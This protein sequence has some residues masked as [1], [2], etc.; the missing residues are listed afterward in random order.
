MQVFNMNSISSMRPLNKIT[1]VYYCAVIHIE[2]VCNCSLRGEPISVEQS[3]ACLQ[4]GFHSR[5]EAATEGSN[6]SEGGGVEGMGGGGGSCIIS[7]KM[8]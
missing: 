2:L 6:N 8:H 1:I 4:P 3:R 5:T 7:P